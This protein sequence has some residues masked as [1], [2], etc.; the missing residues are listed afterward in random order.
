[1]TTILLQY[2]FGLIQTAKFGMTCLMHKTCVYLRD[3]VRKDFTSVQF[4]IWSKKLL[5]FHLILGLLHFQNNDSDTYHQCEVHIDS[6]LDQASQSTSV[7]DG[8]YIVS[9]LLM[10][11]RVSMLTCMSLYMYVAMCIVMCI[12]ERE[13]S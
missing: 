10:C 1:M 7:P 13:N 8:E 12:I 4:F 3:L 2:S 11:I 9:A 5:G 6:L